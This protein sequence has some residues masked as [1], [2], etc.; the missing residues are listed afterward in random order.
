[1]LSAGLVGTLERWV[2]EIASMAGRAELFFHYEG[3]GQH[4]RQ[5]ENC[6]AVHA[7]LQVFATGDFLLP[8][9]S[10]LFGEP[11]RLFKDKIN[12]KPPGG[13]GY[14]AHRDGR[15]WW[16][17][18]DGARMPG[19]DVYARDFIS[20][21]I[22]IDRSTVANGCLELVAGR[23]RR[24]DLDGDYGPLTDGE[25]ATMTFEPCPTE[26]GDVIFFN[27]LTP[28]RSGPNLTTQPRR[29]IDGE[30]R[31][32]YFEDKQRSLARGAKNR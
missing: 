25:A 7:E 9:V 21:L 24:E 2:D 31:A 22:S 16:T 32:R 28:H 19:W 12:F 10:Q 23:H 20:V 13:A 15:F 17:G 6:C 26:P 1:M 14:E 18:P 8:A 27:A 30:Q 29:A 3:D 5:I 11:A 4:V